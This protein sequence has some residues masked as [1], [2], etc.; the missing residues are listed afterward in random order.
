MPSLPIKSKV[1]IGN[2]RAFVL[3]DQVI[4]GAD[5][6]V[7]SMSGGWAPKI[8]AKVQIRLITSMGIGFV[9]ILFFYFIF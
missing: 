4:N 9:F 1:G 8:L 6:I 7:E 2:L 3:A 5:W